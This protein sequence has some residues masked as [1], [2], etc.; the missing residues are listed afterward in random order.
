MRSTRIE[1][2]GYKEQVTKQPALSGKSSSVL[3]ARKSA[4]CKEADRCQVGF[5][6]VRMLSSYFEIKSE[7][8]PH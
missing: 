6:I 5:F 2:T 8:S 3:T 4:K 7:L 1:E